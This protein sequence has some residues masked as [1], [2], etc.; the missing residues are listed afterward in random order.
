MPRQDRIRRHQ[1]GHLPEQ[2]SAEL[3]PLHRETAALV[4]GEAQP[5]LAQLLAEDAVLLHEVVD[6]PRLLPLDQAGEEQQEQLQGR[7]SRGLL[8]HP[9]QVGRQPVST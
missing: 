3:L 2:A 1:R 5:T 8:G 9:S 6:R 7:G 4:V